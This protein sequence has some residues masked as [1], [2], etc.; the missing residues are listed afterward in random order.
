MEEHMGK[1]EKW[2]VRD[3]ECRV[4]ALQTHTHCLYTQTSRGHVTGPHELVQ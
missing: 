2:G 3:G 4:P 1:R